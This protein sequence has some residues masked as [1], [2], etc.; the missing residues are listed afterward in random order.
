MSVYNGEPERRGPVRAGAGSP[1][2]NTQLAG[3]SQTVN[4]AFISRKGGVG[5]TTCTV[6]LA[7]ALAARGRRVLVLDLDAQSSASLSLGVDRRHLAPSMADVLLS[8]RPL[9]ETIRRTGVEGLDLVTGSTDLATLEVALA[10][11]RQRELCLCRPLASIRGEYDFVFMD[12]PA[13]IGLL[14]TSA[15]VGADAYVVPVAPQFLILSGLANFLD[16]VDR[17]CYHLQIRPRLLGVLLTQ[18]DYRVKV[19]RDYV[20]SLRADLNDRI[21]GIEVRVN[22]RLAEAPSL[23]QTIFQYDRQATGARAFKLLSEEFLLR[24]G[25]EVPAEGT[26]E[27]VAVPAGVA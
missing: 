11:N 21:F 12:C 24:C 3:C 9:R 10:S 25:M 15:L 7:A 8:G 1:P 5:K 18:V 27:A 14:S 13:G 4:I 16:A 23:G 26:E 19:T 17:L 22:V 6:N 20:D 2:T